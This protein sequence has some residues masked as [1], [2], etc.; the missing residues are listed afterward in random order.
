MRKILSLIGSLALLAACS[1]Q[2]EDD[3]RLDYVKPAPV[4]KNVLLVDF[5]G[6]RCV[7]CPNATDEI[8]ALQNQYGADTVV[9]VAVHSGPLG[10]HGT[11]KVVGLATDLGDAYYEKWGI[12][13]QPQGV[14][15]YLGTSDYTSWAQLVRQQLQKQ[16]A[17]GISLTCS[18]DSSE[19]AGEVSLTGLDGTVEGYLQLWLTEDSV[20]A[21]QMMP[22]GTA[23]RNYVHNHVFRD[24]IN[25]EEGQAVSLT[26]GQQVSVTFTKALEDNWNTAHLTVVAFVYDSQG[27]RQVVRK[28]VSVN[29]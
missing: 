13:Y 24:A 5:T 1:T 7:N 9:A 29:N 14:V 3:Q 22:D 26:E 16:A 27:V 20:V 18:A 28:A 10:F 25:G 6:Q 19:L 4:A 11:S 2:V 21:M 8:T 12:E 15:D 23:N 17:V